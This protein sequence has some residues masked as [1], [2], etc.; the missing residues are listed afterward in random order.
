MNDNFECFLKEALGQKYKS[1]STSINKNKLPATFGKLDVMGVI[2]PGMVIADVG[3]GKF[4]NAVEWAR[5]KGAELFVIDPYNRDYQHNADALKSVRNNADVVTINNVLN[6]I[7]EPHQRL[8]VLM[9]AYRLLK[10]D[11]TCYILV[12][13]GDK[14]GIG[15]ETQGSKSWQNNSPLKD[16]LPEVKE[17]F[18]KA[19]IKNGMIVATK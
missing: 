19:I 18:N 6:V 12:Y 16:Y 8:K 5:S 17:V 15:K 10:N 13:E 11:G 9:R 3:G 14:T 4:D 2:Q 1:A 7:L